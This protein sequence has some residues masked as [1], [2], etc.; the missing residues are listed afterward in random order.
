MW[1]AFDLSR[2]FTIRRRRNRCSE[3]LIDGGGGELTAISFGSQLDM[4][5]DRIVEDCLIGRIVFISLQRPRMA[6][7]SAGQ[8]DVHCV[9]LCASRPWRHLYNVA[10]LRLAG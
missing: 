9:E 3:W 2:S 4:R 5:A 1:R 8:Q 7:L 10:D 6:M